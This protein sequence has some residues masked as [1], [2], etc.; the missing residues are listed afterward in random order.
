MLLCQMGEKWVLLHSILALRRFHRE[1]Q[2]F[3][4]LQGRF[5]MLETFGRKVGRWLSL[6]V[7]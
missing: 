7:R 2:E 3:L 5:E 4:L 1:N 6:K